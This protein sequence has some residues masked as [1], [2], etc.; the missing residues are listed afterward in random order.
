MYKKHNTCIIFSCTKV[1]QRQLFF[2]VAHERHDSRSIQNV[3]LLNIMDEMHTG[4]RR[5]VPT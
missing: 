4:L 2:I 1:E 5:L 3:A